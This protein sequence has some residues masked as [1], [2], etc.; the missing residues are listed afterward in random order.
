M[1]GPVGRFERREAP[2]RCG[3]ARTYE[4]GSMIHAVMAR[5][6]LPSDRSMPDGRLHAPPNI[7]PVPFA[8]SFFGYSLPAS[9]RGVGRTG[10]TREAPAFERGAVQDVPL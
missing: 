8:S 2:N 6:L 9:F 7:R 4:P 1:K 3:F 10:A 5:T